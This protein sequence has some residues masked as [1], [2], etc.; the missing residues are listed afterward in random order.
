M[1]VCQVCGNAIHRERLAMHSKVITCSADCSREHKRILNRRSSQR[2]Y[3][4]T[5][6]M[7]QS[8]T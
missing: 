8:A 3:E 1:P 6:E 5:R 7:Q 2:Q 4:R